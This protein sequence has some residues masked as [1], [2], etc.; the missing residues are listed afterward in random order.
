MHRSPRSYRWPV[1][2]CPCLGI[3]TASLDKWKIVRPR[4]TLLVRSFSLQSISEVRNRSF[5]TLSESNRGRPVQQSLRTGD[6]GF[7]LR[8]VILRERPILD[9]E[10]A[11]AHVRDRFRQLANRELTRISQV[12]GIM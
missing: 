5:Q 11:A 1:C 10:F 6:V 3:S 2:P 7:P 4:G 12:H 8:G 9:C